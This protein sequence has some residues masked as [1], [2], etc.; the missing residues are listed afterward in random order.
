LIAIDEIRRFAAIQ[1]DPDIAREFLE[2]L[3]SGA[4]DIDPETVTDAVANLHSVTQP[5]TT[6]TGIG[7]R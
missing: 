3:E 5:A 6:A 2:V 1:F 4:C 7:A